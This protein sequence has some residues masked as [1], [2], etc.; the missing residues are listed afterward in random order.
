VSDAG[1]GS[2][3]ESLSR[4]LRFSSLEQSVFDQLLQSRLKSDAAAGHSSRGFSLT[5]PDQGD[6]I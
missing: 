6:P 2:S 3:R 1:S 4:L 5:G